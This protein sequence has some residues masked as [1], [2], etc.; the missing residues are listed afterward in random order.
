MK[1][2]GKI[3]ILTLLLSVIIPVSAKAAEDPFTDW[4]K[5]DTKIIQVPTAY[6]SNAQAFLK[7]LRTEFSKQI[8]ELPATEWESTKKLTGNKSKEQLEAALQEALS[9]KAVNNTANI[10][11]A[12]KVSLT[13]ESAADATAYKLASCA[14][15]FYFISM[16]VKEPQARTYTEASTKIYIASATAIQQFASS[17]DEGDAKYNA[18][19]NDKAI[20]QAMLDSENL[21]YKMG[22]ASAAKDEGNMKKLKDAFDVGTKSCQKAGSELPAMILLKANNKL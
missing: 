5:G 2:A 1:F 11:T 16:Q 14:W 21:V 3:L 9:P 7:T 18:D 12:E 8:S 22:D 17:Y 4:Y 19:R 15:H 20:W 6:N 13:F 10:P